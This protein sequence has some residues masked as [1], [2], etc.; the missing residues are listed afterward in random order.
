MCR[1]TGISTYTHGRGGVYHWTFNKGNFEDEYIKWEYNYGGYYRGG[2]INYGEW[3][4][5]P[6]GGDVSRVE[7]MERAPEISEQMGKECWKYCNELEGPCHFCGSEGL[8]CRADKIMDY[9]RYENEKYQ[10]QSLSRS[11]CKGQ[12]ISGKHTCTTREVP[13]YANL[14]T[15]HI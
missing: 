8:C 1:G 3:D 5:G 12:G 7:L 13:D 10:Y 11:G 2:R 4:S 6:L 9:N 15:I 14:G